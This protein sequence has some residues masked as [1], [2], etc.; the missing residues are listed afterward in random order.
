M[1]DPPDKQAAQATALEEIRDALYEPR[2]ASPR[3]RLCVAPVLLREVIGGNREPAPT[4][5]PPDPGTQTEIISTGLAAAPIDKVS[6]LISVEC[7]PARMPAT[8]PTDGIWTLE[9]LPGHVSAGLGQRLM[10]WPH[11]HPLGEWTCKV[12][13]ERPL[14]NVKIPFVAAFHEVEPVEEVSAEEI[15]GTLDIHRLS[16]EPFIFYF[17]N[18]SDR[19]VNVMIGTEALAEIEGEAKPSRIAVK[20]NVP[21]GMNA[22][23]QRRPAKD[24]SQFICRLR[25]ILSGM[26]KLWKSLP[27]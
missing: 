19:L 26:T 20:H 3:A 15:V 17:L 8:T 23:P 16:A 5:P 10:T 9:V 6:A 4:P 13:S 1:A 27:M 2:T 22:F 7:R 11:E 21:I 12:F 25:A 24:R 18:P 14:L